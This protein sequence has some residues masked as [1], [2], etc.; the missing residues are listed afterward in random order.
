MTRPAEPAVVVDPREAKAADDEEGDAFSL[1]EETED[2]RLRL[3]S[4]APER[5]AQRAAQNQEKH[6]S[7]RKDHAASLLF[8]LLFPSRLYITTRTS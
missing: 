3:T 2:K 6:H 5:A 4:S 1:K 7:A 8:S